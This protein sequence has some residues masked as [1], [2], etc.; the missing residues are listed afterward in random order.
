MLPPKRAR[1]TDWELLSKVMVWKALK[2]THQAE[3]PH[4]HPCLY[5]VVQNTSVFPS[6]SGVKNMD[7]RILRG[8][9]LLVC[10]HRTYKAQITAPRS[11][12]VSVCCQGLV[13]YDCLMCS[14]LTAVW[15]TWMCWPALTSLNDFWPEFI[16]DHFCKPQLQFLQQSE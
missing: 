9:Y 15:V 7:L 11:L 8:L 12:F 2:W 6:P 1:H 13:V 3:G 14:A 16:S 10:P 4:P 5:F